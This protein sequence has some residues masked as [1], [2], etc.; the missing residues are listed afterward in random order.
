MPIDRE[1][2]LRRIKA[3]ESGGNP[4]A[5]SPLSSASGLYGFTK[6]AFEGLGYKWED[7]FNPKVQEE[8]ARKLTDQTYNYLQKKGIKDPTFTDL[9]GAHWFGPQ[10]YTKLASTPDNTSIANVFSSGVLKANPNL[11]KKDGTPKTV[12]EVKGLIAQKVGGQ[13]TQDNSSIGYTDY[14]L[15][16]A[17]LPGQM[18]GYRRDVTEEVSNDPFSKLAE[19][20]QE[21]DFTNEVRQ[22]Q[23]QQERPQ[24]QPNP[25]YAAENYQLQQFQP[26]QYQ[27]QIF[28]EGFFQEGGIK[29]STGNN[30]KRY[31][32]LIID[33]SN[34]QVMDTLNKKFNTLHYKSKMSCTAGSLNCLTDFVQPILN[35]DSVRTLTQQ[36]TS[37]YKI[38]SKPYSWI[39]D[40]YVPNNSID[41]WEIHSQ[42]SGEGL[43]TNLINPKSKLTYK[44]DKKGTNISQIPDQLDYKNL[45]VGTILGQGDSS[46]AYTDP[47]YGTKSRHAMTI[48]G[49]DKKDGEP[50]VYDYG[51]IRRLSDNT[52]ILKSA[53]INNVTIPKGYEKYTMGNLVREYNNYS[54]KLGYGKS[55]PVNYNSKKEHILAI[56]NGVNDVKDQIGFDYNI[57]QTVI[58][59]MALMLPG[60]AYQETGINNNEKLTK[61]A[62][63]DNIVGNYVGKPGLKIIKNTANFIGNTFKEEGSRKKGYELEIEA[64]KKY[65]NDPAKRKAYQNQL[66]NENSN[67]KNTN[68]EELTSS[69]GPFS[70]KNIPAYSENKLKVKKSDMFGVDFSNKSELKNGSKVAL[71]ILA[72]NYA[73]AKKQNPNLDP[74]ELIDLSLASYNS[75]SKLKDKRY[76]QYFINKDTRTLNDTYLEKIKNF[77][78]Q[79]GGEWFGETVFEKEQPLMAAK[80]TQEYQDAMTGMMKSKIGMGNALGSPSIKRMSRAMPKTG[81]TPEGMGTHYMGSVD[82]YAR[83]F[84]QD[85]GKDQLEYFENPRPSREDIRFNSPEEAQYFAERYKEV[86]PM[87]T[88]YSG[89][90]EYQDGGLKAKADRAY[91]QEIYD[92]IRPSD[93]TSLNNYAR[94]IFSVKRDDYDDARSEE[95]FKQYLGLN[96]KPKYLS[97]SKYAPSIKAK[98]KE[99]EYYRVDPELENDIFHSYKDKVKLN[100]VVPVDEINIKSEWPVG[101]P[102]TQDG[103]VKL[104]PYDDNIIVGRPMASR[105]R[106]LGRF[107][108]SRGK[109]KKGEYLSYSDQYDFPDT[110]QNKMKGKPYNVYNRIYY[111]DMKQMG[112][113]IENNEKSF[114]QEYQ[115][116]GPFSKAKTKKVKPYNSNKIEKS[117][118]DNLGVNDFRDSVEEEAE[119]QGI[120]G[121]HN[122]G[123]D[124]IRHASSA[125]KVSSQIPLGLGVLS[126]N[127]LGLIHE[128]SPESN[129][130]ET[131]SDLYNNFAGSL[132]GGIPFISD[133]TRSNI[134]IEAQKRGYLSDLGEKDEPLNTKRPTLKKKSEGGTITDNEKAFLQEFRQGGTIPVSSNGVYDYPGQEVIVPTNSGRITMKNVPYD[135]LGIDEY[136]NQQMMQSNGEYQYPGKIIHEIP[137]TKKK[138]SIKS[139]LK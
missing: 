112:G 111:K 139:K 84:L 59:K 19:K 125:A 128:I 113:T 82:N 104:D 16:L 69:V 88:T 118:M 105:A 32:E 106:M 123:L 23:E 15:G 101:T 91:A 35:S 37:K 5:K 87:S 66:I 65:P 14:T 89:L 70:V 130:R 43:G 30:P 60:L 28:S 39:G 129:W 21:E 131:K 44:K 31:N 50:L 77:K 103:Y 90:Q 79:D 114:L 94:Y 27:G 7:R 126:A 73:R 29:G 56:Q 47:K 115:V 13:P 74:D 110:F 42:L 52:G 121:V 2:Y 57:P 61:S 46:N 109:D 33:T 1:E 120:S 75:G 116:G 20:Q 133:K 22:Q 26:T 85:T 18:A 93:Y 3:A 108:V 127:V 72:E 10:G 117:I 92:Q 98:G 134:L 45:P 64:Y 54:T 99:G 38:P 137:Q 63:A 80:D 48:I 138:I 97:P 122:G 24:V 135:I 81:M 119:K 102:L 124:A 41:A 86:A 132:V 25:L 4:Y 78:L 76:I 58:N 67:L 6:G 12:G 34:K 11:L 8:A 71:N 9:Y 68:Y 40:T 55:V 36:N 17:P 96:D 107:T 51:E 49:Y 62:I 95:A 100:E 53:P 83:P 136:G